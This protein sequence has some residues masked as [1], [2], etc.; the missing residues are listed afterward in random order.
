MLIVTTSA[1]LLPNPML[2]AVLL[3]YS[4]VLLLMIVS[5]ISFNCL[6]GIVAKVSCKFWFRSSCLSFKRG[7]LCAY[8][9]PLS[10]VHISRSFG[11]QV[12]MLQSNSM[13]SN[14]KIL[15][16]LLIMLCAECGESPAFTKKV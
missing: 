4:I 12:K 16:L 5:V 3:V 9:C 10:G 8:C 6:N 1:P 15:V 7:L 2:P 13:W 11:S 14:L